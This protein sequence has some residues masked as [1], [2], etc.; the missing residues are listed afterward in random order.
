M[1]IYLSEEIIIEEEER[2]G[3]SIQKI[4]TALVFRVMYLYFVNCFSGNN[5]QPSFIYEQII[6]KEQLCLL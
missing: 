2:F 5:S 6:L 4:E 1:S 3:L